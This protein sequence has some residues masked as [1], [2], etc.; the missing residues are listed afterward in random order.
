VDILMVPVG[1]GK[2]M[3][4]EKAA[5]IVSLLEPKIV[6]PMLY[7]TEAARGEFEPVDRFVKEMGVEAGT[8]ETRLSITRSGLPQ[9]TKLVLLGYRG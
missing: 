2:V 8:P 6:I 3:G 4:A 5:E 1:G 9:D 7:K